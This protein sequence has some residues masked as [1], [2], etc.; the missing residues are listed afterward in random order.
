MTIKQQDAHGILFTRAVCEQ[1]TF[2]CH[3][4]SEPGSIQDGTKHLNIF[5]VS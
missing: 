2:K 5:P 4:F 1:N 3:H